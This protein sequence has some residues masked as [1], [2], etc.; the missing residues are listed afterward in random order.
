MPTI[1]SKRKNPQL[2]LL[3]LED[4]AEAALDFVSRVV[5]MSGVCDKKEN[6]C[7]GSQE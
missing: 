7:C 2:D 6:M 3:G 5:V 4:Q 1:R